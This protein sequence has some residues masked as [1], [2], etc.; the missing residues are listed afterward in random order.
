MET[1]LRPRESAGAVGGE[2]AAAAPPGGRLGNDVRLAVG[3]RHRA[4]AR[5][6]SGE[7][8]VTGWARGGLAQ[9]LPLQP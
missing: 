7:R 8:V 1:E 6:R 5:A 9:R 4:H 3:R 2:L